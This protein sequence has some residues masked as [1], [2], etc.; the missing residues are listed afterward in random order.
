MVK[1]RELLYINNK[2]MSGNGLLAYKVTSN[3]IDGEG[4]KRNLAGTMRRQ[5]IANKIKLEITSKEDL[6]EDEAQYILK[7]VR[8]DSAI[9]RFLDPKTKSL[10]TIEAYFD[11]VPAE[12]SYISEDGRII[13]KAISFSIIEM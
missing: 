1:M 9:V 5:V 3:K 12:I 13:Y 6:T 7:E 11:S 10:E 4:T 2:L 8:K